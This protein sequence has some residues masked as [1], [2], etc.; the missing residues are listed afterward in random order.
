MKS[1]R[2][3]V[4]IQFP[5]APFTTESEHTGE[6]VSRQDFMQQVERVLAQVRA[7]AERV[8]LRC[9]VWDEQVSQGAALDVVSVDGGMEKR[10]ARIREQAEK[11]VA[12]TEKPELGI[13]SWWLALDNRLEQLGQ[14]RDI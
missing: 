12:L 9:I 4:H 5:Q 2:V 13:V 3:W 14:E 1:Y 11:L 10:V 7:D 6:V 8:E